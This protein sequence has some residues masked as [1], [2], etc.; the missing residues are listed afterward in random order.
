MKLAPLALVGVAAAWGLAFVLMKDSLTQQPVND[1]LASRFIVATLAMLAMR[2]TIIKYFTKDLLLRGAGAGFFLGM[3]YIFQTYGLS[4]TTAAITGFVTG[5]Y[6]VFTP[7]IAA[8]L[9][10]KRI[11]AK[12]WGA[13]FLATVGLA[14]LSLEGFAISFGAVLVLVSAIFFAA[15]IVSLGEWSAGRDVYAMTIVQLAMCGILT[16]I[17]AIP[18]GIM[19]PPN[20]EV[21]WVVIF[22]AICGTAIAFVIQTWAQSVMSPTTVAVLLT[23]ETVWAAFF[24]VA[25]GGENLTLRIIIG[26]ILVLFAMYQIIILDSRESA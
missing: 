15:H 8:A 22:T 3:G 25:V 26:G 11:P 6:V 4:H 20:S 13:V 14:F 7:L 5:L 10:K 1:F 9:L 19:V 12:A 18:D 23:T 21:W 24:A 16:T 17:G 2:P